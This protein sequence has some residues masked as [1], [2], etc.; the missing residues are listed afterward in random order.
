MGFYYFSNKIS[1]AGDVCV[2]AQCTHEVM[3]AR[4]VIAASSLCLC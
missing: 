4:A 3:E 1:E 2:F